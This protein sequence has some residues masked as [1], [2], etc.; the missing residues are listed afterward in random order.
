MGNGHRCHG[1]NSI[2][3]RRSFRFPFPLSNSLVRSLFF[4][5][6]T[7]IYVRVSF[8]LPPPPPSS[9]KWTSERERV[10]VVVALIAASLFFSWWAVAA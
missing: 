9:L 7:P 4:Y 3:A 6:F 2:V 5:N 8:L 1:P 10:A